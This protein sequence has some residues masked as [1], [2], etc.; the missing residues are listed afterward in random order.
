MMNRPPLHDESPPIFHD[1]SHPLHMMNH[2]PPKPV[3]FAFKVSL[4]LF[5]I[6]RADFQWI[7][8]RNFKMRKRQVQGP[9]WGSPSHIRTSRLCGLGY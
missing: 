5:P 7:T 2:T 6:A 3:R 1:E 9:P 8:Y 4:Y